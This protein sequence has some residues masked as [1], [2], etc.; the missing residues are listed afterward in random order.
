MRNIYLYQIRQCFSGESEVV[1]KEALE[2][3]GQQT[4]D[5]SRRNKGDPVL[6]VDTP[7]SDEIQGFEE[8]NL[9]ELQAENNFQF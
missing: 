8:V 4:L 3:R 6:Q 7:R 1:E 9:V 5:F 2:D